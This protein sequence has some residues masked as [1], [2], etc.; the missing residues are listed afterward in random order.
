MVLFVL[1]C[2]WS[3]L[4]VMVM[5]VHN[6][7][8]YDCCLSVG[9]KVW[10]RTQCPGC[11]PV[12]SRRCLTMLCLH[13]LPVAYLLMLTVRIMRWMKFLHRRQKCLLTTTTM[14]TL[15]QLHYT[16]IVPMVVSSVGHQA[17]LSFLFFCLLW[18][19]SFTK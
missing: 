10:R 12:I 15:R 3:Y 9:L 6:I 18:L 8:V 14:M 17:L 1:S 7:S 19:I 5:S 4:I 13:L 2:Y 11:L 16:A